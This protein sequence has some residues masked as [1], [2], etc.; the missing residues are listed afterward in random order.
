MK[1]VYRTADEDH[2]L[3]LNRIREQQPDRATLDAYFG[4]RYWPSSGPDEMSLQECVAKG[5]ELAEGTSE[6]F[7]WLTATNR[8]AA[9]V[10]TAA[11]LNQGITQEDTEEGYACDHTSK[12][13]LG[14]LAKPGIVL[15]L[16][17][18]LDKARGFVNGA[19]GVVVKHAYMR[20]DKGTAGS[21]RQRVDVR[22]P[23]GRVLKRIA[24]TLAKP[25]ATGAVAAA[26]AAATRATSRAPR[27]CLLYTSPSPRD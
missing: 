4:D 17:R 24:E 23:S 12:S 8:G 26:A 13:T 6:V 10:C 21:H 25:V 7:T 9:E 14:I 27:A 18:N 15:R 11:L 1:T 2:L 3:F 20:N 19:V 16:I 22:L 5:M